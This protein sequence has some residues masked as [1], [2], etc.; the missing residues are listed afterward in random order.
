MSLAGNSQFTSK[1][2]KG[3]SLKK[4]RVGLGGGTDRSAWQRA[5][6]HRLLSLELHM[7]NLG[8]EILEQAKHLMVEKSGTMVTLVEMG[9]EPSRTGYGELSRVPVMFSILIGI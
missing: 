4:E 1:G 9:T 3:L 8:C 6:I 5:A 2:S 7:A